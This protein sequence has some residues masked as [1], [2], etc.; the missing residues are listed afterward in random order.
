[1]Q[2]PN[3]L[4]VE[5]FRYCRLKRL[6]NVTK[7][8]DLIIEHHLS[9]EIAV[10]KIERWWIAKRYVPGSYYLNWYDN[11][12]E[13]ICFEDNDIWFKLHGKWNLRLSSSY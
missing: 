5:I 4:L 6:K 11:P 7:R 3:E 13:E 9:K 2:L 8:W 1:M 10:R 12:L